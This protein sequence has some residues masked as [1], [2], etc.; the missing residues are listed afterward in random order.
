MNNH[1]EHKKMLEEHK[2]RKAHARERHKM[3]WHKMKVIPI[4]LK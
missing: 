1:E 2:E 3:R 4:T